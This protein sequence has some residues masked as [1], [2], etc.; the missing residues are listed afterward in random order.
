MF[1]TQTELHLRRIDR[2]ARARGGTARAWPA[3]AALSGLALLA[4]ALA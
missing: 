4:A 3:L 1:D 2:D